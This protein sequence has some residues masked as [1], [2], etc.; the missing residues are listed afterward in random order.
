MAESISQGFARKF[1]CKEES[2]P[3]HV[4]QSAFHLAQCAKRR[5][6]SCN[7]GHVETREHFPPGP[8]E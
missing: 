7:I 5:T 8:E 6:C 4:K 3:K 2:Q 1:A